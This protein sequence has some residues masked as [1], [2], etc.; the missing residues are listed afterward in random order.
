MGLRLCDPLPVFTL[1]KTYPL[2][3]VDLNQFAFTQIYPVQGITSS[4]GNKY[5]FVRMVELHHQN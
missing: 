2:L 5:G 1:A 4:W 3:L